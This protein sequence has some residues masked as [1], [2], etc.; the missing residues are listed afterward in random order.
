[1]FQ[2]IEDQ[3]ETI[4]KLK[5]A[6]VERDEMLKKS[7][8][9]SLQAQKSLE[10]Q[11]NGEMDLCNELQLKLEKAGE[12]KEA[13]K[14][15]LEKC[16][17]NLDDTKSAYDELVEKWKQKSELITELEVKVKEMKENFEHKEREM[18]KKEKELADANNEMM[19]RLKRCDDSF[20]VQFD[21]EKKGN[22]QRLEALK[23]EYEAKL[24]DADCKVKDIEDEMRIVLIESEKKKKFYEEKINS[25]SQ[26]FSKFQADIKQDR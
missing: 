16:R 25:F 22:L 1:M 17:I 15:E 24:V 7:R 21:A 9:E 4:K 14:V 12:R 10:K 26:M 19:I 18:A 2:V 11:L 6:L 5:S 3:T 13:L 8:E 20:R 23:Q